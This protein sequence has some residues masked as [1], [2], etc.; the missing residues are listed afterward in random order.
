MAINPQ[1][2]SGV[3]PSHFRVRPITLSFIKGIWNNLAHMLVIIRHKIRQCHVQPSRS[4]LS[5]WGYMFTIMCLAQQPVTYLQGQGHTWRSKINIVCYR[6]YFVS[7]LELL[8]LRD[9]EITCTNSHNNKM[10]SQVQCLHPYLQGQRL[11][12]FYSIYFVS[13][14]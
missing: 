1:I 10:I 9:F 5:V 4:K 7:D 2:R 6:V 3:R 12:V 14:S 11:T 8:S 13:L